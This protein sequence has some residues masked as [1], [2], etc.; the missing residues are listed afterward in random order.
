M[1]VALSAG[2][3]RVSFFDSRVRSLFGVL[4]YVVI[5]KRTQKSSLRRTRK[6][7]RYGSHRLEN[8]AG[9]AIP[10]QLFDPKELHRRVSPFDLTSKNDRI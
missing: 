3:R 2:A 10:R 6:P 1:I 4:R 9:R 7:N 8:P 5:K